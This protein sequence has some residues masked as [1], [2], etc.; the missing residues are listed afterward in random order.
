MNVDFRPR[1][2]FFIHYF[3]KTPPGIVCP[4]YY[5]LSHANGCAYSCDY[6]YLNLTFRGLKAPVIFSNL[7]RLKRDVEAWLI[8]TRKPNVLSAG[9]LSD[10][11]LFDPV[12]G[13]TK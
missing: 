10:S 2:S 7:H 1:K 11:L 4:H 9:E 5:V 12:T 13:M 6:C 3:D 8:C